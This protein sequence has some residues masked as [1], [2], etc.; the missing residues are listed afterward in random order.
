MNYKN[1]SNLPYLK[2][3]RRS[4][5]SSLTPAEAALW[6]M[7]GNRKLKGRKFRRQ[8]SV[9]NYILDFFCPSERLA[10][11]LDGQVHTTAMA[12]KY[13]LE[14]DIILEHTGIRV[15]RF[16]NKRVFED[17]EGVLK[18]IEGNFGWWKEPPDIL[19]K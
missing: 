2:S 8:H 18:A 15:L 4:L 12:E 17:P 14:R 9:G 5:R 1:I 11:E 10:V 3:F 6:T 13:D 7:L 16:E 19:E